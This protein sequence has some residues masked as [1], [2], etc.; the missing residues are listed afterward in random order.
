M[1]HK[2]IIKHPTLSSPQDRFALPD[3]S[4]CFGPYGGSYVPETLY[5]PLSELNDAYVEAKKDPDFQ[6]ELSRLLKEF[7]GRP[8]ELYF[9]ERLTKELGVLKYI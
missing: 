3:S 8:T 2:E 4:G 5:H 7:A 1:I 9:A 6:Q